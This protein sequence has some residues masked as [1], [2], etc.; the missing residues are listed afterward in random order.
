MFSWQ[1]LKLLFPFPNL[2]DFLPGIPSL[3]VVKRDS[4]AA[5]ARSREGLSGEWQV[6]S[7]RPHFKLSYLLQTSTAT[8][9]LSPSLAAQDI[10]HFD[11]IQILN[12]SLSLKLGLQNISNE[13]LNV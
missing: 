10:S 5:E 9:A 12:I 11:F 3:L 7:A 6:E 1:P 13:L 2:S 8:A 4:G